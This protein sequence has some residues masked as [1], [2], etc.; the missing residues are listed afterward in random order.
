MADMIHERLF[1]L[2][3]ALVGDRMYPVVA[4]E[5]VVSPFIVY[6]RIPSPSNAAL[7]GRDP[8]INTRIQIDCY[9]T[10]FKNLQ[11]LAGQVREALR[12]SDL[13]SVPLSMQDGPFDETTKNYR[14][15]MDYSLWHHD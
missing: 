14:V 10:N 4:P 9:D 3:H 8:I 13:K 5:A 1:T 6:T 2:L 15:I 7:D 11:L 12:N